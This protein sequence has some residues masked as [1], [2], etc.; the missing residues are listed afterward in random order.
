MPAKK[1]TQRDGQADADLRRREAA[2]QQLVV[3]ARVGGSSTSWKIDW[4][5]Q[6]PMNAL[7]AIQVGASSQTRW[8]GEHA[9]VARQVE[10]VGHA[11]DAAGAE[12]SGLAVRLGG[13]ARPAT[14]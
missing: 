9:P 3:E 10:A 12:L 14:R 13:G 2:H 6:A 1:T 5:V 7:S 11:G 8:A 4:L